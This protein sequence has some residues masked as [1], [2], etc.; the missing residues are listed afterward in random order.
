[1][2]SIFYFPSPAQVLSQ[3][4]WSPRTTDKQFGVSA[5]PL[6]RLQHV[7][8]HDWH[9]QF[10]VLALKEHWNYICC[11]FGATLMN[12]TM[13]TTTCSLHFILRNAQ[14][15]TRSSSSSSST[16]LDIWAVKC[17]SECCLV[18]SA[19]PVGRWP[20]RKVASGLF[21]VA[22]KTIHWTLNRSVSINKSKPK[23]V[24]KSSND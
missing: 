10:D 8:K 5:A 24:F 16:F 22:T 3:W 13:Q 6:A 14:E 18:S 2:L 12:W 21:I 17:C 11:K 4:A 19:R 1:M 9:S 23:A 20:P 7:H 15:N